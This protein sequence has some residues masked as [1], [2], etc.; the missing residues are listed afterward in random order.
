MIQKLDMTKYCP[1]PE[2]EPE[3]TVDKEIKTEEDIDPLDILDPQTKIEIEQ[4]LSLKNESSD[5]SAFIKQCSKE[6]VNV[7]V[8]YTYNQY[9]ITLNP[10]FFLISS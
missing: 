6:D 1:N 2:R 4:D 7:A 9:Q 5:L 3:F 10:F 8:V